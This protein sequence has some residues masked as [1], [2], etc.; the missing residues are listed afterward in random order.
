MAWCEFADL[1]QP[2]V[3][4]LPA[5]RELSM[6]F[7][8][9]LS[10]A[11]S[12]YRHLP[13]WNMTSFNVI[14]F[15]VWQTFPRCA[16]LLFF[17]VQIRHQVLLITQAFIIYT[18]YQYFVLVRALLQVWQKEK[19]KKGGDWSVFES[20]HTAEWRCHINTVGWLCFAP[21]GRFSVVRGLTPLKRDNLLHLKKRKQTTLP[22]YLVFTDYMLCFNVL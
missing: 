3:R 21:V 6:W 7:L 12:S 20:K 19:K 11:L 1:H 4:P 14:F 8:V 9:L 2:R 10:E 17:C 13:K 5:P 16:L 15:S 18:Q 22:S